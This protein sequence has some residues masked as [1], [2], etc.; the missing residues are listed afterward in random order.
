[1]SGFSRRRLGATATAVA[2][3]LSSAAVF[4]SPA[5]AVTGDASPDGGS[6]AVVKLSNTSGACSGVLVAAQWVLTSTTCFPNATPYAAPPVAT[7]ATLGRGNL[8]TGTD[9]H[10]VAVTELVPQPSRPIM[11]ARLATPVTDVFIA[12]LATTPPQVGDSI[13]IG[14]Y[15]RTA[16]EWVPDQLHFATVTVDTLGTTTLAISSSTGPT[17]CKGDAG[18]PAWR[19]TATGATELLALHHTSWQGG[20]FG[21]TETRTGA[22]ETRIDDLHDTLTQQTTSPILARYLDL[23]GAPSF[24]GAPVGGEFTV[25]EGRGQG[26]EHGA[27][28]YSPATGPHDVQGPILAKYQE[29][30]GPVGL[31]FPI[32]DQSITPDGIGR[33]NH[34][35]RPDEAS[36][37]WSP[38]TGAHEI[39]GAIRGKWASM[40]WE[41]GPGYPTTDET[42]TADGVGRF[43]DFTNNTSIYWTP[44]TSV[45]AV[46]GTI[47]DTWTSLGRETSALGY[48]TSDEYD[49]PGGRRSDFQNGYITWNASNNTTQVFLT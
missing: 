44:T 41:T 5:G 13:F 49:I 1:M 8:A 17:T 25:A 18:G 42:S 37:Y 3:A 47:R 46:A 34:F 12:P 30:N 20:C 24:L 45:H 15:G 21:E 19:T 14:G 11:L 26:Y 7:T 2:V 23:G 35:N 10:V 27:I 22:T 9:G 16:T 38:S 43:N 33:Y 32:N 36:I 39:Q 31:G 40:G 6:G 4:A 29:F 48:P 28:Y